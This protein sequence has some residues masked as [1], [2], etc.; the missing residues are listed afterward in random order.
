MK[1]A[2]VADVIHS[3]KF[4]REEGLAPAI[5]GGSHSVAGLGV[6]DDGIV[7]DLSRMKGIRIDPVKR[8][9]RVGGGCTWGDV[10][11]ATHA[12][13]LATPGGIISTTG[14]GGLT[15][16]GGFGYLTRRYG[17]ACDNLISADVVCAD[18]ALRTASATENADLFW[19]S[20]AAAAISAWLHHSNSSCTP[21]ALYMQDPSCIRWNG[22]PK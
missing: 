17:L 19:A 1:C 3:V 2:D 4:A 5:R 11:H 12:F 7:I 16:G 9:A 15:T 6:C 13:G 8:V 20:G 10:D 18:G 22:R 21:S 14:V